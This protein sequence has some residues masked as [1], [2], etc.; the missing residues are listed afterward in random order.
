MRKLFK[1]IVSVAS[2]AAV[3]GGAFYFVKKYLL[4]DDFDDFD[5]DDYFDDFDDFDDNDFDDDNDEVVDIKV[6]S[7]EENAE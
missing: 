1:F 5:E 2:I 3:V 6:N 4:N 7:N